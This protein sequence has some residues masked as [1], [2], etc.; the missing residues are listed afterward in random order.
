MRVEDLLNEIEPLPYRDRCLRLAGLRR[1]AGEPALRTLL[2]E[3][4]QRG[5]YERSLALFIATAVRDEASLEHVARAMRD[6]D[7]E[8]AGVAIRIGVRLGLGPEPFTGRLDDAPAAVRRAAYEAIRKWR[9]TDLADALIG[10]VA[11]RW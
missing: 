6:P 7:A 4:G 11:E 9:R 5:H 2:D 1:L 8:L 3:L 10:P